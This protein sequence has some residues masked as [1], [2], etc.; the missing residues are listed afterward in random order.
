[1]HYTLA[2]DCILLRPGTATDQ[3][4]VV[5]STGLLAPHTCRKASASSCGSET[6][7]S[8]RNIKRGRP[9]WGP[10]PTHLALY[11][12]GDGQWAPA[13]QLTPSP[14][15]PAPSRAFSP[16]VNNLATRAYYPRQ[17][18]GKHGLALEGSDFIL[19]HVAF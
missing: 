10:C 16:E 3:G 5:L 13:S 15:P 19:V 8:E 14:Q 7:S 12:S 6:E 11:T 1:M 2:E 18:I 4:H 17:Q 9:S